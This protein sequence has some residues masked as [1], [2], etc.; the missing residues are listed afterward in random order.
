[1]IATTASAAAA[2]GRALVRAG[3]EVVVVPGPRGHVALP[4]L[5]RRLAA[6]GIVS[7]L[8]EGGGELAAAA[9]RARVVDRLLLV[10]APVLLGGDGRPMLGS[11]GV[12]RLARA[13]SVA[14]PT[15]S[16]LGQD[17]LIEGPVAYR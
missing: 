5:L 16:R 15:F 6:R 17:L 2:R 3:A 11:L 10:S 4:S 1:V 12:G 13:P 7:V 8:I 14:N 9:L